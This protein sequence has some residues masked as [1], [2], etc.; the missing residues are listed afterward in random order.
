MKRPIRTDAARGARRSGRRDR[1][2]CSRWAQA[3]RRRL[4][5]GVRATARQDGS[6]S[7]AGRRR[8]VASTALTAT[9]IYQRDSAGVVSI[10]AV[11]AEGEDSG[12]GI[13]LNDK[14]LILTNDHV[15]AGATQ[16]RGRPRQAPRT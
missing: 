9:Q 5:A 13:V 3:A 2:G 10:K 11:T 1:R 4:D 6:G 7:S 14:G 12:T 16:P 15:V 8:E